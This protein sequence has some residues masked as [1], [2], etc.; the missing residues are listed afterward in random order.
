MKIKP[1]YFLL[2]PADKPKTMIN[3][4][5]VDIAVSYRGLCW[6]KTFQ[7]SGGELNYRIAPEMVIGNL[8]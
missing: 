3:V 2:F 7:C 1:Y 8:A 4:A 5:R 6:Q